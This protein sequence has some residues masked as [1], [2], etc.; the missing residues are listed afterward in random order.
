LN[1]GGFLFQE[2]DALP[3]LGRR[4]LQIRIRVAPY[5]RKREVSANAKKIRPTPL[6][7]PSGLN[8]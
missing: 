2:G 6:T 8:N 1:L 4:R 7:V 5:K 3:I